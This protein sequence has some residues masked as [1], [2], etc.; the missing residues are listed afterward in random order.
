MGGNVMELKQA[1][2]WVGLWIGLALLFNL[3]VL[4]FY[5]TGKALEFLGGYLIELSLSMDNLFLF[6]IIFC[7]FQI[8]AAY[9]KRVLN[10]GI[11]G[12]IILRLVFIVLG[13]AVVNRF[14][15]VLYLFG[16]LLII[17]GIKMCFK[18]EKNKE[19]KESFI[20]K[21]LGKVLPVT[22]ELHGERFL[23]RKNGLWHAT[24]LLAILV[25]IEA[26]DIMFAIDSIPAIFAITTDPFIV[27]S[28]NIFAILGLRSMYFVLEK[29]HQAFR[30]V[31]YGVAMI[32]TF[33]GIK[34][35]LLMW[36][37]EIPIVWS[38]GIIFAILALSMLFSLFRRHS[39]ID[40]FGV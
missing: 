28:S 37:V 5:G 8:P 13:V 3:G 23:I 32:L 6:L 1:L 11:I 31:Q 7:S 34:L 19:M 33:T 39:D 10:Y 29:L 26:S 25:L 27:Y 24:P 40:K 9:Q 4:H 30:Y 18:T 15:W 38:I 2:K 22:H 14:H 17:S 20:I 35:S 36:H 16:A 21:L 12:A